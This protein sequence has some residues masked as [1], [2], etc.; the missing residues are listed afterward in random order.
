[1]NNKGFAVSGILYTIFMIFL[2]TISIMLFNLQNRKTILD[3]LKIDAVN[4]VESDNN[5]EY[6]LNEINSLKSQ[7]GTKVNYSTDEVVVGTWIDN[8]TVYKKTLVMKIDAKSTVEVPIN[9]TRSDINISDDENTIVSYMKSFDLSD[10]NIATLISSS[11]S[12]LADYDTSYLPYP[13]TY[14]ARAF[15]NGYYSISDKNYNVRI[16]KQYYDKNGVTLYL[17]IEYTKLD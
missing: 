17:T 5:Y 7:I 2:V 9:F 1:M 15:V 4:A 10:L 6:L 12:V 8:K 16:G 13:V 14:S 3:E 11:G